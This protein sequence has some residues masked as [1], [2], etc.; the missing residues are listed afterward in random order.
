[1][2]QIDDSGGGSGLQKC[3]ARAVVSVVTSRHVILS[4]FEISF[5][6][7]G[8]CSDSRGAHSFDFEKRLQQWSGQWRYGIRA[9]LTERH[10]YVQYAC[11]CGVRLG[12]FVP[13]LN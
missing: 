7:A 10:M 9:E 1:M 4:I 8:C 11:E 5:S 2:A 13:H 6:F 3:P 12:V